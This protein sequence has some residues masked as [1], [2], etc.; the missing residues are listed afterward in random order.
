M[1]YHSIP[2]DISLLPLRKGKW[3]KIESSIYRPFLDD[4]NPYKGK[5]IWVNE[6]DCLSFNSIQ[7]TRNR[8]LRVDV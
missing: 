6:M 2:W 3:V 5:S 1:I 7:F 8:M 4:Q